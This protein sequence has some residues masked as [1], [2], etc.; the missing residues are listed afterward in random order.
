MSNIIGNKELEIRRQKIENEEKLE[1]VKI[2]NHKIIEL[3]KLENEK[4]I[5]EIELGNQ[6]KIEE[7]TFDFLN[8]MVQQNRSPEEIVIAR[9]I[10]LSGISNN[11]LVNLYEYN[12]AT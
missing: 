7:F 10:L 12:T 5:F 11:N 9:N 1:S 8:K 2:N 4:K 3:Q 6:R